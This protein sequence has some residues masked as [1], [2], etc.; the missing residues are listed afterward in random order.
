M[1]PQSKQW[2]TGDDSW[3]HGSTIPGDWHRFLGP[4]P[5]C[6]ARCFNYG[7]GWRCLAEYCQN[8]SNNPAPSVGETPWWWETDIQ[9][10][11][12]GATDWEARNTNGT[13]RGGTPGQ[14]AHML[15]DQG[16]RHH[17]TLLN[18]AGEYVTSCDFEDAEKAELYRENAEA[19]AKEIGGSVK[20]ETKESE[21]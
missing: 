5:A 14:A 10:A 20:V 13:A 7:G 4:C 3:V 18:A 12:V 19:V 6:G 2:A 1:K 21:E 9:V 11:R 15:R 8:S 16:K 17:V